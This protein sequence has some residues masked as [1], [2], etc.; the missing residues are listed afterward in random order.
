MNKRRDSFVC[1]VAIDRIY[2]SYV[3]I[4]VNINGYREYMILIKEKIYNYHKYWDR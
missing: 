2:C 4:T 1:I 3:N